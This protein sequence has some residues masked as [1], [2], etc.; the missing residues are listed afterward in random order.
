MLRNQALGCRFRFL[1]CRIIYLNFSSRFHCHT[2]GGF[3][4]SYP[5][6]CLL[7][8]LT[9]QLLVFQP[10][11]LCPLPRASLGPALPP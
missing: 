11:H 6:V 7:S 9:L 1:L 10:L 4:I 8:H 3:S 2:P 5:K